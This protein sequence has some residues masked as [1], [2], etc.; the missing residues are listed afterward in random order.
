[1]NRFYGMDKSITVPEGKLF[2]MGD[3]RNNSSDSR[4]PNIGLID[5]RYVLGTVFYRIGDTKLFNTEAEE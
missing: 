1:M 3:N 4:D 5:E 2:V